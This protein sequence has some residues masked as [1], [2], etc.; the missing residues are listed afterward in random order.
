MSVFVCFFLS[1]ITSEALPLL[2]TLIFSLN[3]KRLHRKVK[4][5]KF[6]FTCNLHLCLSLESL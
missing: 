1:V 3:F 4:L 2:Q 6:Y 5:I